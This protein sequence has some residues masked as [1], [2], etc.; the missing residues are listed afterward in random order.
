[1][2]NIICNSCGSQNEQGSAF[3]GNCGAPLSVV[4]QTPPNFSN[5]A[6]NIPY[7]GNTPN[8][9]MAYGSIPNTNVTY[10]NT[11]NP[12][13]P[14]GGTPN[15]NMNYGQAP[16]LGYGQNPNMYN[17]NPNVN[18]NYNNM[19]QNMHEQK[20]SPT[21]WVVLNI[22]FALLSLLFL[23]PVLGGCA[24]FFGY[25][26]K[27]VNS[28]LGTTLMIVAIVCTIIGASIGA[29]TYGK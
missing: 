14:Y 27:K 23:P 16:N 15:P 24:I 22:V 28:K 12:N 17:Q 21:L 6:G 2:S 20:K 10:G 25:R 26:V 5:A 1:V 4:N 3:C 11:P 29:M 13:V 8:P 9:N 19:Q 18:Y 7:T